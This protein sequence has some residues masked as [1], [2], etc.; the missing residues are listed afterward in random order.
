MRRYF[1]DGLFILDVYVFSVFLVLELA[2]VVEP[3]I[4]MYPFNQDLLALQL[5][6]PSVAK[7]AIILVFELCE[8]IIHVDFLGTNGTCGICTVCCHQVVCIRVNES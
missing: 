2:N 6:Q 5:G 3:S 7:G 1:Q 4:S 8:K